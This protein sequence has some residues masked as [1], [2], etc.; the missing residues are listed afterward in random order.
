[1]SVIATMVAGV[2]VM[3]MVPVMLLLM[4]L[5]LKVPMVS[6]MPVVM[7][8]VDLVMFVMLVLPEFAWFRG[9]IDASR[10]LIQFRFN[11]RDITAI[12]LGIG[13]TGCQGNRG[14]QGNNK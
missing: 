8:M 10:V 4:V 3:A 9:N 1:M 11:D 7:M 12:T 14:C 5:V 6:T 13:V 2:F